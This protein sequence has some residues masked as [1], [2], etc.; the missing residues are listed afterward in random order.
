MKVNFK[1]TCIIPG[2]NILYSAAGNISS[3]LSETKQYRDETGETFLDKDSYDYYV[4]VKDDK[5]AEFI[6]AA[7]KY[8]FKIRKD[9]KPGCYI[10]VVGN[11]SCPEC[12][13]NS[14]LD[15]VLKLLGE[16]R[17]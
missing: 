17:K 2:K 6:N 16:E 14:V 4:S 12:E 8:N 13:F 9:H 1:G 15:V 5:E 11:N 3:F 7:K 10:P